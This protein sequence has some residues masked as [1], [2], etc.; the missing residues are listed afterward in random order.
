LKQV[1]I[2]RYGAP[3]EVARC[4]EVADVGAPAAGEVVFDVLAT[5]VN[6]A[7]IAFC[8]GR[9]RVR[10]PLPAAPGAECV[11]RVTAVG[12]GV[13]G[14]RPDDLVINLETENWAERRRV[15]A[16]DVVALPRGMDVEQASMLRANPMTARLLLSDVVPLQSGDWVI[17]NV[18]N[19]AAGKHLIRLA[20]MRG[21]HTVNVV[22]RESLFGEL[23][24]LGADV[25]VIDGPDLV[26]HVR[27]ATGGALPRLAL[28]ALAGEGTAR[29]SECVADGGTVC[30]YGSV[31]GADPIMRR[32]SLVYRGVNLVGF[33]LRRHLQ[34]Y[35]AEEVRRLYRELAQVVADGTLHSVVEARY[36][37]TDIQA[38]LRHA[39][40]EGRSG[41]VLL[42]PNG[43]V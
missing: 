25:C 33:T 20:A 37:I 39:Q 26:E 13:V 10:P 31:T 17:Q 43:P 29:L 8:W 28:D 41:K 36:P 1:L 24:A 6:P 21:I 12:A 15:R 23:R 14:V 34:R 18:A 35:A 11:G 4:A 30:C 42:L 16:E 19:S 40:R 7:D 27:A 3:H 22:R 9:Y 5:P 38:A 2:D 32:T